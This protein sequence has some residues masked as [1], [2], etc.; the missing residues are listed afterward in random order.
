[1]VF[2]R[3]YWL[4]LM[5]FLAGTANVH[6]ADVEIG[7][8]WPTQVLLVASICLCCQ[9]LIPKAS[10]CA[11]ACCKK[12][13]YISLTKEDPFSPQKI[14]VVHF[15]PAEAKF[16]IKKGLSCCPRCCKFR[17]FYEN[18]LDDSRS[19]VMSKCS[20]CVFFCDFD[21]EE[22][23]IKEKCIICKKKLMDL[24][25][26]MKVLFCAYIGCSGYC[27]CCDRPQIN[28]E[29]TTVLLL[30]L[31]NSATAAEMAC[32]FC[33]KNVARSLVTKLEPWMTAPVQVSMDKKTR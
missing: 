19:E 2:S 6:C 31:V 30:A 14:S 28:I 26:S 11:Q 9:K 33:G 1:M 23:S 29:G 22:P 5:F 27:Y 4:S 17:V 8:P 32:L 10:L 21:Q 24:P 12:E 15:D 25:C 13:S 3:C 20:C 16:P 18:L 7:T